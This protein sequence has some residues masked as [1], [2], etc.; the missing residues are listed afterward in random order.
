MPCLTEECEENSTE[1]ANI[2]HDQIANGRRQQTQPLSFIPEHTETSKYLQKNNNKTISEN[3][4]PQQAINYGINRSC[5]SVQI[6]PATDMADRLRISNVFGNTNLQTMNGDYP[7]NGMDSSQLSQTNNHLLGVPDYYLSNTSTTAASGSGS[8][9]G[10][11]P[12]LTQSDQ[13]RENSEQKS[14]PPD[15]LRVENNGGD[16]TQN[17]D[18]MAPLS[19]QGQVDTNSEDEAINLNTFSRSRAATDPGE[20]DTGSSSTNHPQH[21]IFGR[22]SSSDELNVK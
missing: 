18:K 14:S 13:S 11:A 21:K 19:D 8:E 22:F 15:L 1:S 16:K 20:T 3:G 10:A 4:I 7:M 9:G 12:D 6:S 17:A 5:E 2:S